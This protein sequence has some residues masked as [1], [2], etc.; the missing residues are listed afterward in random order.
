MAYIPTCAWPRRLVDVAQ[1]SVT[2]VG[3]GML[4]QVG[5]Q[6]G[7]RSTYD[8]DVGSARLDRGLCRRGLGDRR[9]GPAALRQ[10]GGR[11]RRA[12]TA[13]LDFAFARQ[14]LAALTRYAWYA[15]T[16]IESRQLLVLAEQSVQTY[17]AAPGERFAAAP[18]GRRDL[19]VAGPFRQPRRRANNA[20]RARAYARARRALEVLSGRY[21]A[22]RGQVAAFAV[23]SPPGGAGCRRPAGQAVLLIGADAWWWQPFESGRQPA[24]L[25]P[26]FSLGL[27]GGASATACCRCCA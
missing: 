17:A 8:R 13:A 23:L 19:D 3:A 27:A 12:E 21:P 25:L 20:R 22:A 2:V 15:T 7:A 5:A 26:D 16:V 6:L 10:Q 4:P 24:G 14:S 18:A 11:L 9:L 1:Q